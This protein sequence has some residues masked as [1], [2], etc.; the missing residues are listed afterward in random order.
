ME[1]LTIQAPEKMAWGNSRA[2]LLRE[3]TDTV[4]MHT[5]NQVIRKN[6]EKHVECNYYFKNCVL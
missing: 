3:L 2:E 5:G 6:K 1:L 4:Y